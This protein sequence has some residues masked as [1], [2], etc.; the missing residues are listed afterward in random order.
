MS[1]RTEIW[2]DFSDGTAYTS[3][4]AGNAS[5]AVPAFGGRLSP[6][7][8]VT[9]ARVVSEPRAFVG[10]SVKRYFADRPAGAG[11]YNPVLA[12]RPARSN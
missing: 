5:G 1:I 11:M 8:A 3:A 10:L 4:K 12:G 7:G 6:A 2:E 9:S